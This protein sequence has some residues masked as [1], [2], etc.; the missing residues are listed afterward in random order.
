MLTKQ[1]FVCCS[2]RFIGF[3]DP[4]N[5]WQY[6]IAA[7][8]LIPISGTRI[9]M[10][11]RFT[12]DQDIDF[13]VYDRIDPGEYLAYCREATLKRNPR[14]GQ[15]TVFLL[16]DVFSPNGMTK[17]ATVRRWI[18]IGTRGDKPHVGRGTDFWNWWVQANDGHPPTRA[19]RMTPR[20]FTKRMARVE[21]TDSGP[22]KARK[23]EAPKP[24][25]PYSIVKRVL[26]WETGR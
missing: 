26:S 12:H 6:R 4:V 21:V 15:W 3:N 1:K 18:Y 13:D 22:P 8:P 7:M 9:L 14:Y 5:D 20:I 19:D 23:G 11:T 24:H 17:I 16:W 2:V 10:L 25:N